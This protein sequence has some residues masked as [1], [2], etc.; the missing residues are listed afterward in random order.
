M[1][2]HGNKKTFWVCM[3]QSTMVCA[4]IKTTIKHL[5]VVLSRAVAMKIQ[6]LIKAAIDL[7][8]EARENRVK[9]KKTK[10]NSRDSDKN[11]PGL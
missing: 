8:F 3:S 5:C 10:C 4:T 9:V 6:G 7:V 1:L 2:I 11:H